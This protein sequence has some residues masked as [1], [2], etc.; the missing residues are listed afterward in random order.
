[1]KQAAEPTERV[2][3]LKPILILSFHLRMG[4]L[5]GLIL[6]GFQAQILVV[7]VLHLQWE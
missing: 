5:N 1:M 3:Y 4:V 6:L 7:G 2:D